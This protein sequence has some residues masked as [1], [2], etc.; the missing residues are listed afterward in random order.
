M[1]TESG[2]GNG[3]RKMPDK[4]HH[5]ICRLDLQHNVSLQHCLDPTK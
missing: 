1:G 2:N 3:P 5:A 4:D